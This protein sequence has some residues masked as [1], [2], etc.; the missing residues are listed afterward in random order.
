MGGDTLATKHCTKCKE[1]K[2]LSAFSKHTRN[3]LQAYCKRCARNSAD[4]WDRANPRRKIFNNKRGHAKKVGIPFNLEFASIEWPTH[5][6]ALGVELDYT[7]GKG[8]ASRLSPSFDRID[9]SRGYVVGNVIIVS[10]LANAIKTDATPQQIVRVGEFYKQLI[11][12]SNDTL[13]NP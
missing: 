5:C 1:E 4:E 7:I 3:G 11:G 9:P 12:G 6:P 8:A 2:P 10:N 13:G